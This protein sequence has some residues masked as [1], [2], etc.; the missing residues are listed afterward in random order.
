MKLFSGLYTNFPIRIGHHYCHPPWIL[1]F[2]IHSFQQT[3][4]RDASFPPT[5]MLGVV[6]AFPAPF[7]STT[8]GGPDMCCDFAARLDRSP[9]KISDRSFRNKLSQLAFTFL[10]TYSSPSSRPCDGVLQRIRKFLARRQIS[11]R[12]RKLTA[13]ADAKPSL[14]NVLH[15]LHHTDVL[16]HPPNHNRKKKYF[17]Q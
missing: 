1:P 4:V 10:L 15:S 2:I 3:H 17:L 6:T 16:Q 8:Q 7:A 5:H 11:P 13:L 14:D 12:P 9:M